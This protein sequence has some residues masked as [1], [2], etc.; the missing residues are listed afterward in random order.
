MPAPRSL[1]LLAAAL[2]LTATATLPAAG[3][4]GTAPPA[5]VAAFRQ[6]ERDFAN[7]HDTTAAASTADGCD[8]IDPYGDG[9]CATTRRT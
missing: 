2:T 4:V 1:V 9:P 8:A 6:G 3:A 5:D 7:R